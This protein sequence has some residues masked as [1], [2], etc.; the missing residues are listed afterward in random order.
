[1]KKPHE[2]R[3]DFASP[4]PPDGDRTHTG[5]D[6]IYCV[7][8]IGSI[9]TLSNISLYQWQTHPLRDDRRSDNI[10]HGDTRESEEKINPQMGIY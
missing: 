7:L 3:S 8:F 2:V 5:T 6:T 1:M 9:W 4:L 10:S